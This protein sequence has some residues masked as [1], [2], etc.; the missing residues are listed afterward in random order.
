VSMGMRRGL[1]CAFGQ[2]AAKSGA[3]GCCVGLLWWLCPAVG[4]AAPWRIAFERESS[5]G[6]PGSQAV[7]VAH[8]GGQ[9]QRRLGQ[10]ADPLLSPNG[11]LVAASAAA[12]SRGTLVIYSTAGGRP[13]RYFPY[14]APF[15]SYGQARPLAWSPDSRFLAVRTQYAPG[16][17]VPGLYVIDTRN[18]SLHRIAI[19]WAPEASFAPR[20]PDRLVFGSGLPNSGVYVARPDGHRRRRL[21][22][23]GE[24]PAWGPRAIAYT[25]ANVG[26]ALTNPGEVNQIWLVA[27]DGTNRRQ[28][29]DGP[30][31]ANGINP[32]M[33]WS[34]TGAWLLAQYFNQ[35]KGV[36][37]PWLVSL[38]GG[39]GAAVAV[40]GC[41]VGTAG[42]S[43]DGGSMLISQSP[44]CGLPEISALPVWAGPS[45]VLI[46]DAF[47]PIE[48][49]G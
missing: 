4:L 39:G 49:I 19:G 43:R 15:P 1:L 45:H 5:V 29:T 37:E 13:R 28:L 38:A 48:G 30:A 7:W 31:G 23:H 21:V 24:S 16:N 11:R 2:A 14:V 10:G 20:L 22:A 41:Y 17:S 42:F 34:P 36:W 8:E 26:S 9:N 40:E 12:G 47:I 25:V 35:T 33:Y 3:V 32:S 44:D 46:S 27:P 6:V 18:R